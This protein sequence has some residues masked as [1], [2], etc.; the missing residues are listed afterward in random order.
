MRTT[1]WNILCSSSVANGIDIIRIFDALNDIKN[2]QT[3]I[4][5]AKKE[6]AHAQVAISYTTGPV[7]T[8][9]YYVKYAK[10]H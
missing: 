8:T 10:Q 2:L 5:A 1:L 3:A 9:E 6:G 7:F 4:K